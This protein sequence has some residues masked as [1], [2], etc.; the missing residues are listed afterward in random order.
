MNVIIGAMR[1]IHKN[2][3]CDRRIE[4][5]IHRHGLSELGS[6][7]AISTPIIGFHGKV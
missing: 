6:Y 2:S 7:V 3:I 5:V 1:A 4:Q